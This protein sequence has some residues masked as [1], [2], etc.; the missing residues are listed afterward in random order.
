MTP[1]RSGSCSCA[2]AVRTRKSPRRRAAEFALIVA[3]AIT[4]V[5]GETW[6]IADAPALPKALIHAFPV[7]AVFH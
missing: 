3:L 4:V 2:D 5:L 7:V 1:S 6:A